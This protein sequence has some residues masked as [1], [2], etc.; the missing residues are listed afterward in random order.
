MGRYIW[1][2]TLVRCR[3]GGVRAQAKGGLW[4][5]VISTDG[6]SWQVVM[7]RQLLIFQSYA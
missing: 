4:P 6:L 5:Q 7:A 1:H 2:Q 3:V